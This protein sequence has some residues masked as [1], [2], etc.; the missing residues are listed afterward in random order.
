M[1]MVMVMVPV[2]NVGN[3]EFVS[4]LVPSTSSSLFFF[5]VWIQLREHRDE[6]Q[7]IRFR[8][9]QVLLYIYIL[10]SIVSQL[11]SELDFTTVICLFVC[12]SCR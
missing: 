11:L 5:V 9:P 1:V 3:A 2:Q 10:V 8:V 12:L 4:C 7:S 6:I